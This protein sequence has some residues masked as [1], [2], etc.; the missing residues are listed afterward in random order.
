MHITEMFYI[1]YMMISQK[2]II[3]VSKIVIYSCSG[4]LASSV[5]SLVS[6]TIIAKAKCCFYL[7]TT[8]GEKSPTS[9]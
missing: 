2:A 3:F 9:M 4:V 1:L 5:L 7:T 6:P 8:L